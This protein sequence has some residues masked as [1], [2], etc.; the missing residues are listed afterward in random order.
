MMVDRFSNN[1]ITMRSLF[2]KS[3]TAMIAFNDVKQMLGL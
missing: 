1:Q 3:K 2:A